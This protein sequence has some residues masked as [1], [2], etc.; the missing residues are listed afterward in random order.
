[1]NCCPIQGYKHIVDLLNVYAV[2]KS[3]YVIFLLFM[4]SGNLGS[5][6][7]IKKCGENFVLLF[8]AVFWANYRGVKYST[9]SV[10]SNIVIKYFLISLLKISTCSLADTVPLEF[11]LQIL[12]NCLILVRAITPFLQIHFSK[13]AFATV[14]ASLLWIAITSV[15]FENAYVI[16]H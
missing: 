14:W 5:S 9:S 15:H 2:Y 8:G 1:M 4:L 6:K 16:S 12:C 7:Y 13:M 10:S 3:E 11:D